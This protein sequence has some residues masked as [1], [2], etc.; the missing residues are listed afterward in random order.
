MQTHNAQQAVRHP[1]M[2]DNSST[3]SASKRSRL[4]TIA[5][6]ALTWMLLAQPVMAEE[7]LSIEP[8]NVNEASVELL[9]ELPGIGPGKAQAIVEDRQANGP[10]TTIEDLTRV[11]G[12]GDATVARLKDE[13]SL[14]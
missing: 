2:N 3:L 11:K 14:R 6:L 10:F 13:I 5:L 8:I 1:S 9:A 7:R 12:I 4:W